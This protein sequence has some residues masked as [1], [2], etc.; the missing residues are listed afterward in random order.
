MSLRPGQVGRRT[1]KRL[2]VYGKRDFAFAAV[3]EKR[4]HT[5]VSGVVSLPEHPMLPE[6]SGYTRYVMSRPSRIDLVGECV[7]WWNRGRLRKTSLVMVVMPRA[8]GK[9]WQRWSLRCDVGWFARAWQDLVSFYIPM[10][11]NRTRAV[12]VMRT[13]LRGSIPMWLFTKSCGATG[14]HVMH[15]LKALCEAA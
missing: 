11:P 10:G 7:S 2:L 9:L 15:T 8:E 1:T 13:D 14:V 4:G 12:M 6:F 5:L 3:E